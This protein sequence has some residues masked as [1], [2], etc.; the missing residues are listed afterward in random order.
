MTGTE[1][2]HRAILQ[3]I[4]WRIMLERGL[5]PDFSAEACAE[6]A[7]IEAPAWT[8]GEQV[9]D[10]R[11]RL[12]ASIDNDDSL[13]LDQLTLAEALPGD[14][15]KISVAVA[16]VDV[17]VKKGSAIDGHARHNTTSVYTAAR[18][19]PMLPEKLS[20][21]LTSLNLNEDRLAIVIEMVIGADGSV[22]DSHIYRAWVRNHAKLAYDGVAAWL[23]GGNASDGIADVNGLDENLRI[24]DR[25]AQRMK[26]FRHLHGALDL[27][28]IEA[29]PTFDGE[30]IRG[31]NVEKR[32]RAK[33]L[34]EDF[35]IAAK[36]RDLPLS[37]IKNITLPPPGSKDAEDDGRELSNSRRSMVSNFPIPRIQRDW[38][39]FS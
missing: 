27:E 18:I 20:T 11:D 23:E 22:E 37:F 16:D 31:L 3:K 35:M 17:I 32:N 38:R 33:E 28:T 39:S 4:A 8:D 2:Q 14:K 24:Q 26:A 30:E 6:L 29:R 19:F 9:R 25:V 13:D 7:G 34:I 36:W 1:K 12:W 21:N 10:L 5:L 15:V